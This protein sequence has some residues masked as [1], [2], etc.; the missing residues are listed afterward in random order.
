[1]LIPKASIGPWMDP[2]PDKQFVDMV[3]G[4]ILCSV[5]W[6]NSTGSRRV[7]TG[8]SLFLCPLLHMRQ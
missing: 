8:T 6:A 3:S 5:P 7:R 4:N 1:M 2:R